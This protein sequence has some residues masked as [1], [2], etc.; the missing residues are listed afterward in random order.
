MQL[1]NKPYDYCD[2]AMHKNESIDQICYTKVSVHM[3]W[4]R[5]YFTTISNKT[6]F[7]WW[8]FKC[9]VQYL[10]LMWIMDFNLNFLK[11]EKAAYGMNM[12]GNGFH[13]N[14]TSKLMATSKKIIFSLFVH[15][16]VWENVD[17]FVKLWKWPKT[18]NLFYKLFYFLSNQC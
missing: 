15:G 11:W 18:L 17:P 13:E 4:F 8:T 6:Y 2:F 1:Y 5:I 10:I 16:I 7:N 9:N 3:H 14:F 12:N